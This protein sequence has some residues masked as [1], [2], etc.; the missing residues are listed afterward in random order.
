MTDLI[1]TIILPFVTSKPVKKLIIDLL[2]ALAQKTENT[3]DDSAV[4][5]VSRALLPDK[6]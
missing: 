1:A 3:L 6:L 5:G 2:Y 4:K